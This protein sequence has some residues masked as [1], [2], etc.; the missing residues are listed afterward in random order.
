MSDIATV[1]GGRLAGEDAA[2]RSV[3]ID[4][5]EAQPGALFFALAGEHHDG[6]AFVADARERGASGAVVTHSDDG[7]DS[8]VV[9]DDVQDALQRLA[10]DERRSMKGKVVGITGSTGKTTTKDLATAVLSAR[11][12][13]VASPGSFNNEIG[14]PLTLLAATESTHV[15]VAEMGARGLGH[16]E[17]LCRVAAP[18]VGIVTN[19]GVAHMELF[20]SVENIAIAKGEL[21]AALDAGGTAILN[22]DDPV[23]TG[24]AGLTDARVMRFGEHPDAD[25]R[26]EGVALEDDGTARFSL[27]AAGERL[28]VRLAIPGEHMVSNALAAAATGLALGVEAGDIVEALAEAKGSAWRMEVFD[29]PGGVRVIND[30]YNANPTSMASALKAARRIA[31]GSRLCSVL[32]TMRELGPVSREEHERIGD[33]AARLHV[34]RLITVGDEARQMA[35]AALREGTPPDDVASYDDADEALADVRSWVRPGDVVLFKGSR[36][37]GLERLAEA[38]RS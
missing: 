21:I 28:P 9:V 33:M 10:A 27:A 30:A 17:E 29:A 23:V 32:G 36:A 19:V 16:I 1:V 34:D 7:A 15:I 14:L 2:V 4:S 35:V 20:G 3:T 22:A 6:H 11:F 24:Y 31:R 25:V 12:E 38:M 18:N 8:T 37:V 5:R 26:A 13:V